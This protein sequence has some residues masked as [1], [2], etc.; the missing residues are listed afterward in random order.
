MDR[1]KFRRDGTPYPRGDDG[2]FAWAEDM[3]NLYY[4]VVAV[5]TLPN[6]YRVS[7]VW[8][9]LDHNF[10]LEG[11]PL[12]FETMVFGKEL[13]MDLDSARY[14]TEAEAMEGHWRMVRKWKDQD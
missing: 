14:A 10:S 13:W 3:Q 2:F 11:P 7:T 8:L 6:G 1:R 4:R 12:I 9:G 5:D